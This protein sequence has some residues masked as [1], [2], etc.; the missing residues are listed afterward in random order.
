MIINIIY[1]YTLCDNIFILNTFLDYM[2]QYVFWGKK[3]KKHF[4]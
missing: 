3:K 4:K 1:N 2:I